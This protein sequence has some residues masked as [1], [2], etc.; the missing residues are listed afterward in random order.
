MKEK[1]ELTFD[2]IK[3][4]EDM[5]WFINAQ[6]F[7]DLLIVSQKETCCYILKTDSGL[8]VF[9]GIWP[10]EKVYEEI[11]NAISDAGWSDIPVTKFIMTHGHIDHVGCGKWLVD[12]YNVKTYLSKTDDLLRLYTPHEDGRSDS[13]KEFTIDSYIDDGD[14]IDCGNKAIEVIHTPGHTDGCMSFVFPISE[15]GRIHNAV[16]F[17]GATP[18]WNDEAAKIIQKQSVE[19][20][21]QIA[22]T[23]DVEV[24]LTNHT[25]FD[26]GLQR[27]EYSKARM[28]HL[29]NIYLL[30][31]KGV[32]D[33]LD[34][35]RIMAE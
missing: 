31:I 29:P 22:E 4:M 3:R 18:S 11:R 30:G 26:S 16:L 33:F 5:S 9:D 14:I 17:G 7:D 28:N 35:F 15:N 32:L 21:K 19:K 2:T 24:A 13:Y 27:I 6:I 23:A 10:D 12:N 20:I 34:V 1:P 25:A 8:V